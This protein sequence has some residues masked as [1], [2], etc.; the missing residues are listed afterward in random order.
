MDLLQL[1]GLARRNWLVLLS[2]LLAGLAVGAGVSAVQPELYSAT[3]AGYVVAGNSSTVGDAFAGS[4]LAAEKAGTYL[5][6]VQSR[7][8]ADAV[9]EE[10]DVSPGAVSLQGSTQGVI[11]RITATAPS[12]DLARDMADAAIRATSVAANDLETLTISGESSGRTVIQIVP[13]ELAQTPSRPVSPDWT[14]NLALGLMLGLL[15]GFGLVVLRHSLD[16]RVRQASEVEEITTSS[17]L[18]VIPKATELVVNTTL[19]GDRGAAAEAMRQ[20]RTNLRFVSV[21]NPPR[22]IVVT[23]A[24]QGEGKST[25]ATHLA[26]LLAESGQPTVLIDADLRRPVLAKVFDVDGSVGLTQVVAGSVDLADALVSTT[27]KDLWLLPAGRIPPNPSEIVGSAR[28]QNLVAGLAESFT[29]IIDAPPLL[30]VTDAGLLAVAADGALLVVRHGQTRR[31]QV[32]LAA[33][34]LANVDATLLGFVVNMVP[35]KDIGSVVYGY[36]HGSYSTQYYYGDSRETQRSRARGGRATPVR[37]EGTAD[38]AGD[39]R[40]DVES[41]SQEAVPTETPENR[42]AGSGS[43]TLSTSAVRSFTVRFGRRTADSVRS[44]TRRSVSRRAMEEDPPWKR[45]STHSTL[46]SARPSP[47]GPC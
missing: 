39:A 25:I 6:L 31:E 43:A 45:S 44:K 15:S 41:R 5:P 2:S 8:V 12:P 14:R 13:V 32:A 30:P 18:G 16:R 21:D 23:S 47:A 46:R 34:N 7:S 35:K 29:V 11:F 4:N 20:V 22:S 17:A 37:K 24:N 1:W 3:S 42:G 36:G 40:V 38:R 9:A 27:Q 28:M 10:L 33:R 19:A 26:S